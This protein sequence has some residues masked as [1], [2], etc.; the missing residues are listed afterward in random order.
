MLRMI[1]LNQL[2]PWTDNP[3]PKADETAIKRMTASIK[4]TKGL[5]QNLIGV[6]HE[7][8]IVVIAGGSRL[9]ALGR[10][11]ADGEFSADIEVPVDVRD[12]VTLDSADVLQ[13]A[14]TENSIRTQMDVIDEAHAM[15]LLAARGQSPAAIA[16][17]F[18]YKKR[19]V[20]QRIALGCLANEA[21]TMVRQG[22]RDLDW[23]QALTAIDA[24]TQAKIV[25]DVQHNPAAWK[26]GNEIR[27]F[28]NQ[29]TISAHHALFDPALYKGPLISD[30]FDGDRFADRGAFWELQNAAIEER[31]TALENEGWS[32]V[33]VSHDGVESWRYGRTTVPADGIVILEV[34]PNG[35]VIEHVGLVDT[36]GVEAGDEVEVDE[37]GDAEIVEIAAKTRNATKDLLRSA[38]SAMLQVGI[39]GSPR[40]AME[41]VFAGLLG[42][43]ESPFR[44]LPYR[45]KGDPKGRRGKAF[46]EAEAGRE[47]FQ[48][49]QAELSALSGAALLDA[50]AALDDTTFNALF[51]LAVANVFGETQSPTHQAEDSLVNALGRRLVANPRAH[52]RP[53]AAYF[54]TLATPQLRQLALS[55]LP[56]ERQRGVLSAK[57]KQLVQLL[58]SAF[59]EAAEAPGAMDRETVDLLNGWVPAEMSF[60]PRA[61]LEALPANDADDFLATFGGD[62]KAA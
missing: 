6:P 22:V 47:K 7:G 41:I 51:A 35:Q 43:Q 30:M 17:A 39:A 12:D 42:Q 33:M 1:P 21:K 58:D 59:E 2:S 23:A 36:T 9:E 50:L 40:S 48:E 38:R 18:G 10:L 8:R 53:N 34:A 49:V 37:S 55:V 16:A 13:I 29:D 31:K 28:L 61:D 19:T 3:R 14:L 46:A 11:V 24:A 4:A 20:R 60:E 45:Y 54:E 25:S 44:Q 62:T 27:R 26:D 56:A 32:A 52:W 57:P 15:A 5:L